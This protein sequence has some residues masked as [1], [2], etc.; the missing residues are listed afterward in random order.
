MGEIKVEN[1]AKNRHPFLLQT[2]QTNGAIAPSGAGKDAAM[3]RGSQMAKLFPKSAVKAATHAEEILC[4]LEEILHPL[5][6]TPYVPDLTVAN[7]AVHRGMGNRCAITAPQSA[8]DQESDCADEF[9]WWI[10]DI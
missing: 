4:P 10:C 5:T 6:T 1:R 9:D 3:A 2:V 8:A 7:V